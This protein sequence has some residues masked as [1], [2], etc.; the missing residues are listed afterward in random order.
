M[1]ERTAQLVWTR[2]P[3]VENLPEGR[4]KTVAVDRGDSVLQACLTHVNGRFSALDNRCPYQGGPLGEGS[5]EYDDKGDCYL[6]CPWNGWDFD[7]V[8]GKPLDLQDP[9]AALAFA[10]EAAEAAEAAEIGDRRDPDVLAILARALHRTG[11]SARTADVAKQALAL[12]PA[13]DDG[14][15]Q[16]L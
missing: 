11:I 7:P 1:T 12:I 6:R 15:R 4:V 2:V 14:R 5:I 3:H 8:T 13:E 10:T 9:V 16:Q